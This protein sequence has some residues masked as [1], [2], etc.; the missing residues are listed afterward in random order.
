MPGI[1]VSELVSLNV[2]DFS[3]KQVFALSGGDEG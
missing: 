3:R 2:T 1:R